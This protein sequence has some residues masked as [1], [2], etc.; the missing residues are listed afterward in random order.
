MQIIAAVCH[1][2]KPG[3]TIET[4]TL[5]AP[6]PEEILVRIVGVGLCH[7]DLMIQESGE[8]WY[9]FPAV[10]GHEGAGVV[11]AIGS[12]VTK[13]Q[14]GDHV[15]L[16]FRSC[17]L[18]N[19]CADRAPA[20]CRSMQALNFAGA[21]ADGSATIHNA[22]GPVTGNFF[23]QSSFASHAL[24]QQSNVVRVEADL[25]LELLGP[26]GCGVQTGAGGV[27]N[28]LAARPGSSILILG[29]GSVGL[30]AVMGAKLQGCATIILVEPHASRR[31]LG[32]E[33]GATHSLD[34]DEM[35]DIAAAVR[36]IAPLG[37]DYA[38][39]STGI[40]AVLADAMACLGSKGV[41]GLVA[42]SPPGTALPGD[43]NQ[44]IAMGQSIRGI[45][46]GDSDPDSFIP[47][48]IAHY[49]AGRLPFDRMIRTYKLTDIAR[50]I[51]DHKAGLVTKAV[52]LP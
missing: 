10:L 49:R 41:L 39:D 29:G 11:E 44:L 17:G 40:P 5:D 22:D 46:E 21:R 16:S 51:A 42:A 19:H 25:P 18:C 1:T 34:P 8:A 23:G 48:L 45:V 36:N 9:R 50:A 32:L 47:A 52:L 12:A 2:G 7:T 6:R 35:P 28:S 37:V 30:S 33:F 38:F 31:S 4:L 14:P 20:Y 27:M 15:V 26:L 13:V 43:I 3:F 24:T